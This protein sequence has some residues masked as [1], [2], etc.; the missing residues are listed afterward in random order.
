MV[1]NGVE[2]EGQNFTALGLKPQII[3]PSV[4]LTKTGDSLKNDE[5]PADRKYV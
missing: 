4:P 5:G 3:L 2:L 1:D